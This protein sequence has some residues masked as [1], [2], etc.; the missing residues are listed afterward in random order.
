MITSTL[1]ILE[2]YRYLVEV[3]STGQLSLCY[4]E[5]AG[6]KKALET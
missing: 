2:R 1:T 3:L 4:E 5:G 6:G